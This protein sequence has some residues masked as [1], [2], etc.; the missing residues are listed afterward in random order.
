[1]RL[2]CARWV[3]LMLWV[4]HDSEVGD[5]EGPATETKKKI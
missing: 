4:A 3:R 1:M 5:V 2:T